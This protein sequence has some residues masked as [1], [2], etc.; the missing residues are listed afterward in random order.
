MGNE[1]MKQHDLVK[2]VVIAFKET[3][4][5]GEPDEEMREQLMD[6]IDGRYLD[7]VDRQLKE[8]IFDQA[9]EE[10]D[11]FLEFGQILNTFKDLIGDNGPKFT[12]NI[13]FNQGAAY[14]GLGKKDLAIETYQ[15]ALEQ[16]DMTNQ[17]LTRANYNLGTV[18]AEKG[19]FREAQKHLLEAQ[20]KG[21]NHPRLRQNLDYVARQLDFIE[22]NT[23]PNQT[24]EQAQRLKH[25]LYKQTPC[26]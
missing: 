6:A 8:K 18:L 24:L 7:V 19:N 17:T 11:A 26:G 12:A 15:K 14:E 16:E 2:Q 4:D 21:M 23:G 20:R 5:R 1:K 13:L 10:Y 25:K 22:D 3:V 9:V